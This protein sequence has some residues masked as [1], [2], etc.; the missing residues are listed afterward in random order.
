VVD[1]RGASGNGP[2]VV[3]AIL[4]TR[5]DDFAVEEEV[6]HPLRPRIV[7]GDG[8]SPAAI[9]EVAGA[10]DVILAG[11]G[12]RFD[13]AT[14]GDLTCSGIVRYGVGTESIDL[15]AA[16][17]RGMWVANVPDYGTDA[18][19]LHALALTLAAVRRIPHA[20]AL[21][22]SG[23]WGFAN[24]RPLHLPS[25]LVAGV[26][27][28]GRIGR[29]TAELLAHVGF[30]VAAYDPVAAVD[31]PDA[32]IS[33]ATLEEVLERSDVVSLHA[34]GR[35]GG[36][37]LLGHDEIAR[38][39]EGSVLVNTARGSL[40]DVAA[41]VDGLAR[42]RPALAALDVFP[43]E[44]PDLAAFAGVEDRLLLSPH[45]AWYTVE[46]ERDL[47]EKAAQEALRILSGEPPLNAVSAPQGANA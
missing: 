13:D 9:A 21:V 16:A 11:S 28:F 26:V 34:P 6:L 38:M 7:A 39:K 3:V 45:M 42:G 12:P 47:R 19:A 10:A 31:H 36:S 20:D 1:G 46:S 24:L 29:R 25:S 4:G 15:D 14:L 18:V 33:E 35:P 2:G 5:Y 43:N 27:G 22:K 37:P 17:R 44:P 8:A 40:I 41:L 23:R 30:T 32:R